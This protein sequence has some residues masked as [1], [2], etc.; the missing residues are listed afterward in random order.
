MTE[1]YYVKAVKPVVGCMRVIT[2][3]AVMSTDN[4]ASKGVY[5]GAVIRLQY[6]HY[7][8]LKYSSITSLQQ[9]EYNMQ[10]S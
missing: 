10:T 7:Q 2:T 4:T 6:S 8:I 1:K 3:V 9:D 5:I